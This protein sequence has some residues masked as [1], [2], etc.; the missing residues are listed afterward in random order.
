MARNLEVLGEALAL[1]TDC[2]LVLDRE[3]VSRPLQNRLARFV[4]RLG[5]ETVDEAVRA[6][7]SNE[8]RHRAAGA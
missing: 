4:E 1:L 3:K 2:Q 7:Y 8:G 5:R 6:F